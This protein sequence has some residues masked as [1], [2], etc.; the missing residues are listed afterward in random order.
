M[1]LMLFLDKITQSIMS[2]SASFYSLFNVC[3]SC[4]SQSK[5]CMC[6]VNIFCTCPFWNCI[7]A[8]MLREG[9]YVGL[10]MGFINIFS[11]KPSEKMYSS[12]NVM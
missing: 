5:A 6:S 9:C 11:S 2:S 4:M 12:R 3:S 1:R 8:L 10:K 7:L